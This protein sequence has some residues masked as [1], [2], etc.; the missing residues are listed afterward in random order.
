M[1]NFWQSDSTPHNLL[2]PMEDVTDTSFRQLVLECSD[3][4]Q[5]DAVFTEFVSVEGLCH[6]KGRDKV[7]HRLQV[8]ESE[9]ALLK[10]KGVKLVAQIWGK[11]PEKYMEATERFVNEMGFDAVDINMGCPVEKI[12]RQ[13]CCSA[14][15]KTPELAAEIV[16][17]VKSVSKVPVSVK[18]RIGWNTPETDRWVRQV[19]AMEPAAFILHGRTREEQSDGLAD[20]NEI[21]KAVEI[22]DE[23]GVKI[24]VYGNGDVMSLEQSSE[25]QQKYGVD[26]VMI[27]RGIFHNPW[28]FSKRETAP[29]PEEQLAL[30]W[31]HT[32]LFDSTWGQ[33]K[34]FNILKRFYK[35]YVHGFPHAHQLRQELMEVADAEG[36][37]TILDN[38]G[39][40]TPTAS[41]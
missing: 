30:L 37:K 9:R 14:L 16:A 38:L 28:L 7:I 22:R 6:E 11:R 8:N 41:R 3:P 2:A 27:G 12:V 31:R 36:V 21:A 19:M 29:T 1:N 23:L 15:I 25:Y 5:L 34:N 18:T 24:P 39:I 20:W 40:P 17:A 13:G 32:Y 35:I 4:G 26:G 33:S 10:A